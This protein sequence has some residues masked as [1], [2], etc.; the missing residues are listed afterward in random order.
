MSK[1][2]KLTDYQPDDKNFNI[3]S[4]Y[5]MSLLEKSVERVGVIES[6]TASCDDKVISGNARQ[7]VMLSKFDGVEPIVVETDGTRPVI[8]KRT[9]IKG[10][11]KQFHVAALLAN[12]VS[13]HN[14]NLDKEKIEEIAVQEYDIDVKEL[15]VILPSGQD[16]ED[17]GPKEYTPTYKFTVICNKSNERKKIMAELLERGFS[18]ETE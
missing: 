13:K 12:T 5:G 11:T 17:E 18:C 15:G 8:L 16:E 6:I 9:D 3:H 2:V 10:N 7:E 14:V 1:K 4:A